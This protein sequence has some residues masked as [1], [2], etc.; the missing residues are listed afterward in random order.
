AGPSASEP[1]WRR[2]APPLSSPYQRPSSLNL[3]CRERA[4]APRVHAPL[5]QANAWG[6]DW[7]PAM[8]LSPTSVLGSWQVAH[9]DLVDR[10][11]VN[12]LP[13]AVSRRGNPTSRSRRRDTRSPRVD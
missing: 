2:N 5:P 7:F 1:P 10:E 12:S 9:R 4:Y 11:S 6:N 13:E 8:A 3:G